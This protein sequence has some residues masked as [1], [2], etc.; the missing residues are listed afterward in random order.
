[1]VPHVAAMS[2]LTADALASPGAPDR[3]AQARTPGPLQRWN[4]G[5][6]PSLIGLAV[7]A[8][9][10][11]ARPPPLLPQRQTT[12]SGGGVRTRTNRSR[13]GTTAHNENE[14]SL[15]FTPLGY[16]AEA[17][18]G[19]CAALAHAEPPEGHRAR[20][21]AGG[22]QWR[23]RRRKAWHRHGLS[24]VTGRERRGG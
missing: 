8:V 22:P 14:T 24:C 5:Q 10:V 1:M 3:G 17:R 4:S 16:T 2:A 13:E 21:T 20:G 11:E 19:G 15:W 23:P 6:S 18:G 9:R 7:C 12:P